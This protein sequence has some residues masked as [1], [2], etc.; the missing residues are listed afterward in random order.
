[1]CVVSE[2]AL[3]GCVCV[4]VC[5]VCVYKVSF[6]IASAISLEEAVSLSVLEPLERYAPSRHTLSGRGRS[7]PH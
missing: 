6:M 2:R 5:V 7:P 4:C 3:G 1:M